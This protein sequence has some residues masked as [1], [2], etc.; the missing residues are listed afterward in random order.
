MNEFELNSAAFDSP[1]EGFS[2]EEEEAVKAEST[3]HRHVPALALHS[4]GL[5]CLISFLIPGFH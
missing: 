1:V 4:D 2:N 3:F 5:R